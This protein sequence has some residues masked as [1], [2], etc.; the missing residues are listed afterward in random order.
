MACFMDLY[1]NDVYKEMQAEMFDYV[2]DSIK[3]VMGG[4]AHRIMQRPR[5]RIMKSW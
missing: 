1:L 2:Y 5:G 4:K 3:D